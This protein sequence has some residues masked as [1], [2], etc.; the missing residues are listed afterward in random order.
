M[1]RQTQKLENKLP[2]I[3]DR[4]QTDR[5]VII[6]NHNLTLQPTTLISILGKL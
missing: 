2:S 6:A 5:I 3:E 1:P 4:G